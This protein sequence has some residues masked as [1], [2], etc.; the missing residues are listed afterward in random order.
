LRPTFGS[1]K[2]NDYVIEFVLVKPK[3]AARLEDDVPHTHTL[4]LKHDSLAD[5]SELLAFVFGAGHDDVAGG[6]DTMTFH[7]IAS[8]GN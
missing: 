5:R 2:A 3:V 1:L 8:Y 4:I 6:N 7:E